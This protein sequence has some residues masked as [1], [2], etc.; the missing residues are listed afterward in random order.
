MPA[1]LLIAEQQ[2]NC[3]PVDGAVMIVTYLE[4]LL[5]GPGPPLD[6]VVSAGWAHKE[7][8]SGGMGLLSG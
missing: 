1:I 8:R 5:V 3:L 6:W 2:Q 7:S 4:L